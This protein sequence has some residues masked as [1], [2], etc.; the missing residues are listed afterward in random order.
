MLNLIIFVEIVLP[1]IRVSIHEIASSFG[2][3]DFILFASK[4]QHEGRVR[5]IANKIKSWL[6]KLD[7]IS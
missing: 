6:P 1:E 7:A 4:A 3:Q 2:S 5:A